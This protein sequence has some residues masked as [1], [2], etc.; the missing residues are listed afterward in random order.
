MRVAIAEAAAC[1]KRVRLHA[2]WEVSPKMLA[3]LAG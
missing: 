1:R 2:K 3:L